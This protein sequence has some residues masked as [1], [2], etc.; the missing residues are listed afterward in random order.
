MHFCA[1]P[2]NQA[3]HRAPRARAQLAHPNTRCDTQAAGASQEMTAD[4][5]AAEAVTSVGAEG[6]PAGVTA[7]EGAEGSELLLAFVAVTVKV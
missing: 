2:D 7:A 4:A 3:A 6:G 1:V 5:S